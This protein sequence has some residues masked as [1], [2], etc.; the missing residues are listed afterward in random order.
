MRLTVATVPL[1]RMIISPLNTRQTPP[2]D[3]TVPGL[4]ETIHAGGLLQPP[5][6]HRM[7]RSKRYGA[8][9]GGRR[10]RAL[11]RVQKHHPDA[12]TVDFTAIPV[13]LAEG[14]DAELV[15]ASATGNFQREAMTD[16]QLYDAVRKIRA[17]GK[18]VTDEMLAE[19]FGVPIARIRRILRLAYVHPEILE[20]YAKGGLDEQSLYAYAATA[21][22][23]LQQSAFATLQGWQRSN[24][25][26]IRRALGLADESTR[27]ML[28]IVGVENYEAAGG[29]FEPDLFSP[30]S[31]RVLDPELLGQ[32]YNAH[33]ASVQERLRQE[34]PDRELTFGD[35]PQ[36]RH[37]TDHRLQADR[38]RRVP[39]ELQER[40]ADLRQRLGSL[41]EELSE[42]V[43]WE[44]CEERGIDVDVRSA[45]TAWDVVPLEPSLAERANEILAAIPP[46][47][48]ELQR[49]QTQAD[50]APTEL[51]PGA[52]H[53]CLTIR[54]GAVVPTFWFPDAQAAGVTKQ[55]GGAKVPAA[56]SDAGPA[57]DPAQPT[58]TGRAEVWLRAARVNMAILYVLGDGEGSA[59]TRARAHKALIYAMAH[60]LLHR[61]TYGQSNFG[62]VHNFEGATYNH[63]SSG[64]ESPDATVAAA[65]DTVPGL[66]ET[67]VAAGF[68]TFEQ[69]ATPEQVDLCAAAVFAARIEG[70]VE[71]TGSLADEVMTDLAIPALARGVWSPSDDFFGLFRKATM[72]AW[73]SG[74]EPAFK[75]GSLKL[76]ELK[77]AAV[78]FFAAGPGSESRFGIA[79]EV[80]DR[81]R[82]WLPSWLRWASAEELAEGRSRKAR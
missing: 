22:Q 44:A 35:P 6:V 33:L 3:P 34:H 52:T 75:F 64:V 74:F 17:T 31:G 42:A 60:R 61:R 14:T 49:L 38:V 76:N 62:L 81:V 28:Q 69:L 11:C 70:A 72:L 58:L 82:E 25:H 48:E 9:D 56:R 78:D 30:N 5:L 4:A 54:D 10:F 53:V 21:D 40:M 13:V 71:P 23:A 77:D 43:D 63:G 32:L 12:T 59:A 67:N 66:T 37:G 46:L 51:P 16:I 41:Q 20:T 8:L 80:T 2:D 18:N 1:D 73:V 79:P 47:R 19:A 7:G 68:L 45:R 15:Q 39:A 57:P 36:D 24:P 27:Q 26:Y 29:G 65:L 50:E 55:A